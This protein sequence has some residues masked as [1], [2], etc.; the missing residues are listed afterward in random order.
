MLVLSLG[1][2]T[3][4]PNYRRPV[5]ETPMTWRGEVGEAKDVANT[6]WWEQFDDPVLNEL[7]LTA[8][9]ENKDLKIAASR[10]DEF[11]GRYASARAGLFPQVGGTAT[12]VR[13][14]LTQYSNPPP[15]P[16]MRNPYSDYQTF[17]SAS[18]ELDIWGRVRR[19]T[20]GARADLLATEEGRRAVIMIVT[21]ATAIGYTDLRFL[22]KQL[23]IARRTVEGREDSL[24]LFRL[25][26]DRGLISELEMR[27]AESEYQAAF[28]TIPV[29][30]KL[31][32]QQENALSVLIGHNPGLI[33]RGGSLDQLTL[34]AVPAGLPSDLLERRPDIREAEQNLI[35][36]NAR[37]GAVKAAYFPT[38]SLTGLFGLESTDLSK[39][40]T[41]PARIW[42]FAAPVTAP[43]F[44]GGARA[45]AVKTAEA[46]QQQAL[47]R[48]QQVIQE[49]F[50]EVEDG[51]ID[52]VKSREQLRIQKQQ[53]EALREY[54]RLARLRYDNGYTSYL[55]VLD[56]ERNLF[57]GELSYA[58]TQDVLFRA[59]INLYKST[60]GGWIVKAEALAGGND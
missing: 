27:Q 34:P 14:G 57:S 15:A 11:L 52:Q 1:A 37:I 49:A 7:I 4:G 38:I 8:L 44:T 53:V 25:R 42:S 29:L 56:A 55:E 59:L 21:T 13:K 50:R 26:F 18:W 33:P 54:E 35:A 10:I 48:Y 9:R 22:D 19:L 30:E 31:I 39:L 41:G 40:F 6:A 12:E 45:G 3:V 23:Q 47:F 43:I 46:I 20:E 24:K 36:A 32:A 58:Q 2:C 17:L 5:V 60:G 51:L 16:T 28:A